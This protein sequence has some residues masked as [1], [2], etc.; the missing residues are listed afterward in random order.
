MACNATLRPVVQVALHTGL[1]KKELLGLQWGD[2]NLDRQ[3]ITVREVHAKSG[4]AREVPLNRTAWSLLAG[5]RAVNTPKEKAVFLNRTGKPYVQISTLYRAAVAKAGI[6]NFRFH[7]LR[8]T[9]A[10]RLVMRGVSLAAVRELLGHQDYAM[11][12]RYAH[13]ADEHKRDAVEMLSREFSQ[14]GPFH[15]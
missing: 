9:F 5:L 10:S 8:H 11:T 6:K 13:L 7:D 12:L 1:R 4:V 14:Q 2:V 3:V 15:G